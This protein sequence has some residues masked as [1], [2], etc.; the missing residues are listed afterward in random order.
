[1]QGTRGA[2]QWNPLGQHRL[3]CCCAA[4]CEGWFCTSWKQQFAANTFMAGFMME[5]L[6]W[7]LPSTSPAL[8]LWHSKYFA[9]DRITSAHSFGN[10]SLDI[11]LVR[12]WQ[13]KPH[14]ADGLQIRL[15][16]REFHNHTRS[17]FFFLSLFWLRTRFSF[18]WKNMA[19][20]FF[21]SKVKVTT[22]RIALLEALLLNAVLFAMN[23]AA[24][25]QNALHFHWL[26]LII[27]LYFWLISSVVHVHA[28]Q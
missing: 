22:L 1:M 2:E 6:A 11:L 25:L 9:A 3:T 20:I 17:H 15:L 18:I 8:L 7:E 28:R 5:V 16:Q 23:F 24:S 14:L 4:L 12:Q 26:V 10:S 19:S 21:S 13:I 27:P